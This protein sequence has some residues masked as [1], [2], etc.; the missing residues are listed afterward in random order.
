[1]AKNDPKWPEMI[2]FVLFV[3]LFVVLFCF[4]KYKFCADSQKNCPDMLLEALPLFQQFLKLV[5]FFMAFKAYSSAQHFQF[6]N[7][8][9]QNN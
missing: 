1:M 8:A 7:S 9:A 6:E 3:V 5:R 2:L 4:Q